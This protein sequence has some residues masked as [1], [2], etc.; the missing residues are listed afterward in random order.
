MQL[1]KRRG[2]GA[3]TAGKGSRSCCPRVDRVAEGVEF[4]KRCLPLTSED[5]G[6]ELSPVCRDQEVRIGGEDAEMVEVI[7]CAAVVAVRELEVSEVVQG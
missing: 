4:L 1:V 3:F 5:I 6:R 7:C 2:E